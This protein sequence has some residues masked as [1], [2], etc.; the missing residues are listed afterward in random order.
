M[1]Q[2]LLQ[3]A[4]LFIEYKFYTMP[5]HTIFEY[6]LAD[7]PRENAKQ[8][9]EQKTTDNVSILPQPVVR[10]LNTILICKVKIKKKSSTSL[11]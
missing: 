6:F 9:I 7:I 8:S 2:R 5:K 1:R 11:N 3:D 10:I 4:L